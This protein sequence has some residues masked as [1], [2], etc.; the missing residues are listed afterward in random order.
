MFYKMECLDMTEIR[1]MKSV[2]RKKKNYKSINFTSGNTCISQIKS[3]VIYLDIDYSNETVV[4]GKHK[5]NQARQCIPVVDS[6]WYLAKLIQLCKVKKK[7]DNILVIYYA[8][9]I[10]GVVKSTK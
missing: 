4:F 9:L 5:F 7:K 6:F 3:I 2:W 1:E 8:K 10:V